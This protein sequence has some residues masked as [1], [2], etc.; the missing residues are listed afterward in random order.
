[1][2]SNKTQNEKSETFLLAHALLLLVLSLLVGVQGVFEIIDYMPHI[3]SAGC[4]NCGAYVAS[5]P[6]TLIMYLWFSVSVAVKVER[7]SAAFDDTHSRPRFSCNPAQPRKVGYVYRRLNP[8]FAAAADIPQKYFS[9][10]TYI[11]EAFGKKSVG[12]DYHVS[13][14]LTRK[15]YKRHLT[16]LPADKLQFFNFSRNA[17]HI[18]RNGFHFKLC[19]FKAQPV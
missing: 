3:I 19:P 10:H 18:L 14:Y 17:E 1:M 11:K 13:F 16:D 7:K 15:T 5:I 12:A 2:L 8:I 6:S 9:V 4:I